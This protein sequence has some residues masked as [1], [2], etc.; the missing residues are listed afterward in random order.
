MGKTDDVLEIERLLN[1]TLSKI[2]ASPGTYF[3]GIGKEEIEILEKLKIGETVPY[4]NFMSTSKS[5]DIAVSFARK[6][7]SKTGNGAII[8][9]KSLNGKSIQYYSDA[10]I[11]S[12]ILHN[13][14]TKFKL[15][16][17]EE[18]KLLNVF[19][20]QFE[21][22]PAVYGKKYILQEIP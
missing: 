10:T 11:D 21:Y 16:A 18:N 7:L 5:E 14:K 6:N 13:S 22:Q 12:E 9:V 8:E 17:V 15:A 2:E 4:K 19:E 20:H 1:N 3:R